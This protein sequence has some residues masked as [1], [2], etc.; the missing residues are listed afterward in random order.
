MSTMKAVW[1]TGDQKI[2]LLHDVPV[3]EVKPGTVKIKIAYAALC[4]TD[5]HAV[6]MGVMNAKMEEGGNG[7]GHESSGVIVEMGPDTEQSGLKPGDKVVVFPGASCG[8]CENCK[9]GFRQYCTGGTVRFRAFAEYALAH[10]SAVYKIP[11]DADLRTYSL[12]EPTVCTIRAMDLSPISHGQTVLVS[13][14]GGIGS[15]LLDMVI[16]SGASKVT[17]SDPVPQKRENALSMGAQYVIDPVGEDLL[18]RGF[19]ITG[20]KGYDHIFEVSGVPAAAPPC[21]DLIAKCGTVTYFAVF[22]PGYD[23]PLNLHNLYMKEGRIQTVF[24][25]PHLMHRA[26]NLIP[27]MQADKIIGRVYDLSD[28]MEAFDMFHK[29]IYPKILLKCN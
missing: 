3:P 2:E 15:I 28:A 27:R 20:G 7:L 4:A 23:L 16:H 24:T 26:I 10:V 25:S 11:D 1:W 17:V 8:K 14:A 9:N 21:L 12:V 18:A 6:S 19:E 13:G 5:I 22:P 29:S